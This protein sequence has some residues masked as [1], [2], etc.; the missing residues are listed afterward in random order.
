MANTIL[1]LFL[2]MSIQK[3]PIHLSDYQYT[4]PEESIAKYPLSNRDES[5]LITWTNGK[6]QHASFLQLTDFLSL[7]TTI[8]FNN[9][10]VIPARLFFTKESGAVIEVFLLAPS[11]PSSLLSSALTAKGQSTWKCTVGNARKWDTNLILQRTVGEVELMA[12]WEN[13]EDGLVT[14]YWTPAEV[15]LATIIQAAGVIPLPPYLKRDPESSDK[16]RYQTIYSEHDG[17]VAAPTAG[18][19]F[20]PVVLE[21]L[22]S[23]GI[24]CEYLTLHVS[25][26]TFLPIKAENAADHRMHEEQIIIYKSNIISLLDRSQLVIAVGTTALR[27]LES[28]YWFGVLLNENFDA[29]FAIP[30]DLPYRDHGKIPSVEESLNLVV[31]RMRRDKTETISGITSLYIM[32]GYQFKLVQGLI[33]NFHQPGSTLLLLISAFVGP[34]WKDIYQEALDHNYRFLSYG[35]SMLLLPIKN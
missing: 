27:T 7:N 35:D 25:A 21:K 13:R 6:I 29:P 9:T 1:H 16:E 30:Q 11:D 5:K 23:K 17:A 8:F 15:P 14:L 32:P 19:H 26:G 24:K 10:R 4:L 20:T 3:Q 34:T 2:A 31:D 33:T 12:R 18:L 22:V 28:M